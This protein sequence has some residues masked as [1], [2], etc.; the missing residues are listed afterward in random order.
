MPTYL[1]RPIYEEGPGRLWGPRP[2][3]RLVASTTERAIEVKT[4]RAA[5]ELV[6]AMLNRADR[7]KAENERSL[8]VGDVVVLAGPDGPPIVL[9]VETIGF[10]RVDPTALAA[11]PTEGR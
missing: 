11:L 4:A 1:A 9:T 6:F 2:D 5:A 3:D 8:S 7:P 10:R